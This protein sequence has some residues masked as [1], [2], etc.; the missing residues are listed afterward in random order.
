[1]YHSIESSTWKYGV[2]S[3][4]F[5]QQLSYLRT[6]FTI[7]PL[8]DVVA[9][10]RGEGVLPDKT[11]AITFDDGYDGVHEYVLPLA[12]RHR[13]PFTVFL[14]TD[15]RELPVLGNLQ[16][17]TESQVTDIAHSG[18]G[19][20]EAH[21][22]SHE[23]LAQALRVGVD[24]H[25]DLSLCKEHIERMTGK[26]PRFFAYPS[27]HTSPGVVAVVQKL[28]DAAFGIT[29]GRIAPGDALYTLQRVQIDRTMS[30]LQFKLRV[31]GGIDVHRAIIDY[32]RHLL[33]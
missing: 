10:V 15:L 13:V 20:I 29:E 23:N 19:Y 31:S 2:S 27:G 6:H 22:H 5:E 14:T 25:A 12:I 18:V 1:M 3:N 21:G 32:V 7:V 16:R 33:S 4:A 11:V 26:A 9:Y 30:F 8:S 17:L 24:V 28:F